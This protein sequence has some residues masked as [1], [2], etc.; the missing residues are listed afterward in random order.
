MVDE[1]L[2]E[3]EGQKVVWE[4][5]GE[6]DTVSGYYRLSDPPGNVCKACAIEDIGEEGL[7]DL[8]RGV[9]ESERTGEMQFA[10]VNKKLW[11]GDDVILYLHDHHYDHGML[12][13]H[14]ED[15]FREGGTVYEYRCEDC[16]EK[17]FARAILGGS[18][19]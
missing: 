17:V 16:Q 18:E 12:N 9:G 15:T 6:G 11:P 1:T 4:G 7:N 2:N 14:A 5:A 3:F 10:P 13:D 19:E 8:E